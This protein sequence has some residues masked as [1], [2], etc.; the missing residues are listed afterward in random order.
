M[1]P[2]GNIENLT[3]LTLM[4]SC[5]YTK[6]KHNISTEQLDHRSDIKKI[7]SEYFKMENK[8]SKLLLESIDWNIE[9]VLDNIAE[10]K[11][12][13]DSYVRD[14]HVYIDV[15]CP[16]VREEGSECFH[17]KENKSYEFAI[18]MYHND[19][20]WRIIVEHVPRNKTRVFVKFL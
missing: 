11:F 12:S 20:S 4:K 18:P 19:T 15:L 5:K 9:I 1:F 3:C 13:S 14:F 7:I 10:I 2:Y 16:I 17:E 6:F 8:I